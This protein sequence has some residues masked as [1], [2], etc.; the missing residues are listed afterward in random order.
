M[1]RNGA[2]KRRSRAS[3]ASHQGE[4]STSLSA[5]N[6]SSSSG[7][8]AFLQRLDNIDLSRRKK[9]K[10]NLTSSSSFGSQRDVES[11]GGQKI[12]SSSAQIMTNDHDDDKKSTTVVAATTAAAS[13]SSSPLKKRILMIFMAIMILIIIHDTKHSPPEKRLF[14]AHRIEKF[15]L[16]VKE[17]PGNGAAAFVLV[18]GTCVVL[19]L[20]GTPLTLGGGYVYKVTYGLAGGVAISTLLSLAGS[21]IGSCTCFILGRYIMRDRV[22]KWGRKY[23]LFDSI[24]IAVSDN[25]FKI[26]CLL[27]LTPILP[28][29]P[30]AYMCGTTSMPLFS[31]AAAKIGAAPL[32]LLYAFIGA[33]TDTFF[34]SSST[35]DGGEVVGSEGD[36]A[37]GAIHQK[38]GMD[39]ETHKKMVLFGLVLSILSMSL[40]SHVVKKELY[41]IFDKQKKDKQDKEDSQSGSLKNGLG[42]QV[43]LTSRNETLQRRQ[44]G[45]DHDEEKG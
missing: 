13:S 41:K 1:E 10:R 44:R 26:M 33:S 40:V 18:Y 22:R 16:W 35:E 36:T 7:I 38:M 30:V 8:D 45:H 2:G 25:G 11:R 23:P 20:P 31:F 42:S 32:T 34:S 12:S 21:L 24:D 43:E 17:H 5:G 29:G 37:K 14:G 39:E 9:D 27:Y 15:L 19:L 6:S 3:A 28:L 4:S